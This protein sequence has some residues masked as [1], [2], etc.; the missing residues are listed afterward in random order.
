MNTVHYDVIVI[1]A[2]F[3]GLT[4]AREL[5]HAGRRVLVLEARDRIGGRTWLDERMGMDLELG[6]TWVHWTQPH[7]WAELARYG[8]GLAPS[9]EPQNASWWNGSEIVH[10]S[11]DELFELLDQPNELLTARAREV[12]P[13]PFAPLESPL[14]SAF[15]SV[16]LLDE[17]EM[18]PIREDQRS[19]L[20]SFWTLNFN[21]RLDDA[22]FTQALR[23]V[24]LTNGDWKINFEACATYKIAG[25]TR[26]LADAIWAD[27]VADIVLGADVRSVVTTDS[28]VTVRTSAGASYDAAEVV[29]AVPLQTVDRVAVEPAFP[30]AVSDAVERGQLGLGTKIWFTIDGEHPPFVALGAADWPLNFLQSEYVHGGKTFVI[31][32]GRDATAIDPAD[33]GAVQD[34]LTR[35]LPG[36]TVVESNGHDWVADVYARET[37]PMHRT[38]FLTSSLAELQR[39]HGHVRLAGSDLADGWGGF[40]DGAIESG[41]KVARSILTTSH[42]AAAQTAH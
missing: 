25:G 28:N 38:G 35:L 3:A 41:L 11:P 16:S 27:S 24:A 14:L 22:A 20:E 19:L 10:G 8:I 40:I 39:P 13:R 32:F 5:S 6:G 17:I 36:L 34:A 30:P 7:V 26:A 33:T 31:G 23:W 2:G 9:P 29:L 37:W 4:A 1:G 42:L 18:L 21:G 15:D 12:F